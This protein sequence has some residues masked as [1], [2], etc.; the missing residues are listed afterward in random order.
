MRIFLCETKTGLYFKSPDQWTDQPELA[1]NFPSSN[2]AVCFARERGLE[3]VEVIWDFED[4]EY[5]VRLSLQAAAYRCPARV[6]RNPDLANQ[7]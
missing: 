1:E 6:P 7:K 5:N 3:T 2:N 4:P